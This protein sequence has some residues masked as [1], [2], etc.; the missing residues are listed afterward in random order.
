MSK[1]IRISL[2]GGRDF[3]SQNEFLEVAYSIETDQSSGCTDQLLS[4]TAD[5]SEMFTEEEFS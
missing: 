3:F 4:S 5:S 1:F 2:E